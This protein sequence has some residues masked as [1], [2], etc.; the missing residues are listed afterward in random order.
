MA[1][2]TPAT[3]SNELFKIA[4]K[5]D[6]RFFL[7]ELDASQ[8]VAEA[9]Y[10]NKSIDSTTDPSLCGYVPAALHELLHKHLDPLIHEHFNDALEEEIITAIER[11][12]VEGHIRKHPTV[13]KKWRRLLERKIREAQSN[14]KE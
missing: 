5:K 3:L 13:M 14:A 4:K 2:W 10:D 12:M 1:R 6:S 8:C 7:K 9:T 11:H